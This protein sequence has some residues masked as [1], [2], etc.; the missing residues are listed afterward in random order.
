MNASAVERMAGS[1]VCLPRELVASTSFLLA[2]LGYSVKMEAIE[3]FEQSGFGPQHYGVLAL[4]EEGARETQGTIADALRVD[5]S[6]LV[7]ILDTLEEGG[8]VER[9]RDP[10]DRRRHLVSLTPAGKRQ[11]SS[12]RKLVERLED[13]VLEPLSA[14]ERS[15]LHRLLLRV[16][17]HR[18]ARFVPPA[19]AA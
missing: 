3:E 11:L 6:Q 10:N 12:F 1:P 2:R 15:E 13:D 16:A 9:R 18:D 19:P 7:G 14:E 5:R 4:L 8:F 17:G